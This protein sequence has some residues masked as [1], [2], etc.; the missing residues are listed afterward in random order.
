MNT[1]MDRFSAPEQLKVVERIKSIT[2]ALV[3]ELD[4]NAYNGQYEL[5]D[6]LSIKSFI[7]DKLRFAG[8]NKNGEREKKIYKNLDTGREITI[9]KDSAGKL[10]LHDGGGEAYKKS[11]AH[12]PEIIEKM[13]LL[14]EMP[15]DKAGAKYSRYSYFITNTR[16]DGTPYT[17]LSTVGH[18]R[19]ETYYDQ[20]VFSGT[21]QEVFRN[22]SNAAD[23]KYE[24]VK[25]ILAGIEEGDWSHDRG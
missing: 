14:A 13:K 5:N 4:G 22:A 19:T 8:R 3:I 15:A 2:T 7:R 12:I 20:N 24:R 17:I 6:L 9:G 23:S 16:I 1:N 18:S 11:I 10:A 25:K 21:P